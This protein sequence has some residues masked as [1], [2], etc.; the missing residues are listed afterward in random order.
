MSEAGFDH[1]VR[2]Y[3]R[4]PVPRP[5]LS[6][7]LTV[8]LA[9]RAGTWIAAAFALLILDPLMRSFGGDS[10]WVDDVGWFVDMWA[11][12]DSGW[13][14]AIARDG[15]VNPE[16]STAFFPLY[17]GLLKVVGAILG[18]HYV[19]AGLLVSL[20]AG[21]GAVL[22]LHRLTRE[23]LDDDAADRA[24]LYVCLF[25]MSIFLLAVYSEALYLL[26]SVATFLLA[27]RGRFLAAG[28]VAGLALLTRTSAVALLPALAVLA[29][30]TSDGRARRLASLAV[31]GAVGTLWP[32]WLW[33][34]LDD[35]LLFVRAQSSESWGRNLSPA[36]PLGGLWHAAEAG[37]AAIRQLIEGPGGRVYWAHATDTTPMHVA[38]VNLELLAYLVLF[39]GLAIVVWRR[40]GPAFGAFVAASLALPLSAPT[41]D[42]P[43]LSLP[44]FGLGIFPIFIALALLGRRP[45]LHVAILCISALL[46]GVTIV[47]WSAG[48]FVA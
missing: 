20:A 19:L 16:E 10:V 35:P 18:G 27:L 43:L 34:R 9:T 24:V 45:R 47:R 21:T 15:Y 28:L 2:S 22:L 8:A 38:A 46:L 44:R 30:Q 29:W 32:L 14:V 4:H 36:G 26:L 17:P 37:W 7:P 48:Q 11:R 3:T 33:L 13:F 6:S 39:L 42:W 31:A 25:P 12:W 40:L 1:P 41:D 23:L 5:S